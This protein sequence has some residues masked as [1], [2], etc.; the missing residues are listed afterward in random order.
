MPRSL[1]PISLKQRFEK[2]LR[3]SCSVAPAQ[4]D[5]TFRPLSTSVKQEFNLWLTVR[6]GVAACRNERSAPM[7]QPRFQEVDRLPDREPEQ[8]ED[9]D[10]RQ[11]LVGLHQIAG[12]QHEG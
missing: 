10:A 11:Q 7:Q 5:T 3:P 2:I 9:D 12:L 1:T 8:G 6:T 4:V